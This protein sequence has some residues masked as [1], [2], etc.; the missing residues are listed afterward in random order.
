M[1]NHVLQFE[2]QVIVLH[3]AV[4]IRLSECEVGYGK[5]IGIFGRSGC[6]KTS[7]LEYLFHKHDKKKKHK[8]RI[9][10]MKQDVVLHP[11]LTVR[12]TLWFYTRLR[13][14]EECQD[15]DTILKKLNMMHLQ[16]RKVGS[17]LSGGEKKR[18]LLAYHLLDRQSC[19][20][21]LDEPFSGLDTQNTKLVFDLIKEKV[22]YGKCSVVMS[23]HQLDPNIYSQFDET[24]EFVS[25]QGNGKMMELEIR[26]QRQYQQEESFTEININDENDMMFI[27]ETIK[28]KNNKQPFRQQWKYLFLRNR[29]IDRENRF[30]VVLRWCTPLMVVLLQQLFIG[31][32]SHYLR[33]WENSHNLV[34]LIETIVVHTILLFTVSISP[35]HILNDHFERRTIVSHETSQG[36]YNKNAYFFSAVLWDQICLLLTSIL[37]ALVVIPP[38]AMLPTI[39]FNIMTQMTSTNMFMWLCS[40]FPQS[41]FHFTLVATSTYSALAFIVN[42]G[43]LLRTH[44]P[45]G[46]IQYTSTTHIQS[47]LFLQKL[48]ELHPTGRGQVDMMMKSFFNIHEETTSWKWILLSL[49]YW[50]TQPFLVMLVNWFW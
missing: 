37:I 31:S 6:G 15:V 42:M 41:T 13:S 33:H 36:L 20:F 29:L 1:E 39:L 44:M 2:P 23:A 11:E 34:D 18:I 32:F 49:T 48:K 45:F 17:G 47:N 30:K 38:K 46:W 7:F 4:Q 8:P 9:A 25:K 40:S 24:W 43:V 3:P 26:T 5:V 10:Y 19:L 28:K 35:I 27:G 21:L 22:A 50:M 14:L 16:N 12:E